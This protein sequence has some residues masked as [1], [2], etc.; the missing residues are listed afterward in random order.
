MVPSII[1]KGILPTLPLAIL[2]AGLAAARETR[3]DEALTQQALNILERRC[4]SCHNA[5]DQK[6][7]V[8]FSTADVMDETGLIDTDDPEASHLLTVISPQGG[9]RPT[10]PKDSDPLSQ[11][12]QDVLRRWILAGADWPAGYHLREP[13]NDDFDWWSFRPLQKP[14]VPQ[15]APE[16]EAW[17]VMP[18]DAFIARKHRQHRLTHADQADRRTLIRRLYYDLTGLPPTP[19]EVTEFVQSDDPAAWD[20]LIDRLLESDRYGERWA[21]HWLDVVKYADTC[22]YD[23]DKLRPN[24]WP[25]RDYVIDSFNLDKPYARFVQEQLAGDVLFPGDSDGIRALG[26]IAA[27]PWDFIGHAE[28]SEDK[29]DGQVARNLDRD[30]MVSNTLNTFCSVTIQC[31]RCHNHKFDPFTQEHY[32]SLQSIFAA[33]DKADRVYDLSPEIEQ[34]KKSLN[35]QRTA[36]EAALDAHEKSITEAGG[37]ELANVSEQIES[38]QDGRREKSRPIEYGYHSQIASNA[39]AAKWV[40]V[41]LGTP[42]VL[43]E[44]RLRACSD[45]FAG[46]GTGFGFPVRFRVDVSDAP[47]DSSTSTVLLDHET[48]DA[49]NPHLAP[50]VIATKEVPVRYIRV[51]ASKLAIRRNDFILALA[52]LEAID[53]DGNN[54]ALNASVSALDSIEAPVRWQRSNLTD[55]LFPI[56]QDAEKAQRLADAEATR[57]SL[58]R[59]LRSDEWLK[60]RDDLSHEIDTIREQLKGLPEGRMVYA[61]ATDFKPISNFKPTMGKPRPVRML[62]RGNVTQPLEEVRPGVIPLN[63]TTSWHLPLDDGHNE[64]DRRAALAEWLVNPDN[65]L[66]WRSVVNRIWQ[67][68]FGQ[69]LAKTPNDFG[70]MGQ[71]PTHPELLDWLACEFRDNG[72]SFKHL[73]RLILKSAVWRQA[74]THHADNVSID[75]SNQYLWKHARRRLSAEELRDSVLKVSGRLNLK[76]G[77]PGYYLFAL[78]KTEHSPHYEYHKFDPADEASH[79][80]SIYRFVVRSQPDPFMTT[81]DC[82]DSSQSTPQRTETFTSLQALSL[83]NNKFTIVMAKAFA[84]RLDEGSASSGEAVDTAFALCTGRQP[85]PSERSALTD[86]V[87]T[88][89]LAAFARL[90]FNLNEFIFLD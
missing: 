58:L 57:E 7:D 6:G 19:E 88:H 1:R 86:Y 14:D 62:H 27:G 43:T 3:A 71:P 81:M 52:E 79:R 76:M 90:M 40:E 41:D 84:D 15:P 22:G 42:V 34:K 68:H 77:G 23:K 36:T 74:S 32:Y 16:D 5:V 59:E 28:V 65:P 20:K 24:A 66:T 4:L 67:Y 73:H 53:T 87:D 72:Q 18:I 38:L 80:R 37:S 49:P 82:A 46:I 70:R 83:L 78:E 50:F 13:V 45:D 39:D 25:Y 2:F 55:G 30:D 85:T 21:R 33:V 61:A 10:M 89:G 63:A 26:F 9:E 47:I 31:A 44:I 48:S 69:P 17:V 11:Q 64:A 56:A 54:V 75:G 29:I 60:R 12:D 35:E 8:V 51:T